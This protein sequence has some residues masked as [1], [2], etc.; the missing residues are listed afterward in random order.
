[1]ISKLSGLPEDSIILENLNKEI[2]Y[3]DSYRVEI[4][5]Y[6]DCSVDY[7][8]ALMFS[9]DPPKWLKILTQLRD[10]IVGLFG[11][12]TGLSH[13]AKK[14]NKSTRYNAGDKIGFFSIIVRNESEIV[15]GENAKHLYFRV[16]LF[17]KKI[18]IPKALLSL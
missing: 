6:D 2:H 1:M 5:K 10:S 17:V 13:I 16:S 7:L 4:E 11:L 3:S 12:K 14:P 15:M 8:T 18:R 9:A